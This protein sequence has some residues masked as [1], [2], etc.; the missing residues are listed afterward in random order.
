M[1]Q[2]KILLN[3][4]PDT[5]NITSPSTPACL[6]TWSGLEEDEFIEPVLAATTFDAT[7]DATT[8]RIIR[9]KAAVPYQG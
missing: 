3:Y 9:L 8:E 1:P 2:I 7:T 6:L 5:G 4:D